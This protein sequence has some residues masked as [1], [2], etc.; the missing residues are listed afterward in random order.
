MSRPTARRVAIVSSPSWQLEAAPPMVV[1]LEDAI[2][3]VTRRH[4]KRY[5]DD[6]GLFGKVV[7]KK[8]EIMHIC[9]KTHDR[10]HTV[11]SSIQG[12]PSDD[13]RSRSATSRE[14]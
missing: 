3:D 13:A 4:G 1:P 2:G 7:Q 9:G 6:Y 10:F 11:T 14:S 5:F 8:K 12:V